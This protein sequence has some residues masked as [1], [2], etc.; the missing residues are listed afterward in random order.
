VSPRGPLS[1]KTAS[2]AAPVAD[3]TRRV[4]TPRPL[5]VHS[6]T[7]L[8]RPQ[9]LALAAQLVDHFALAYGRDVPGLS[10]DAARFLVTRRWTLDDLAA[11]LSRAVAAN[12]GSLITAADL[13]G[14]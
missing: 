8:Y 10:A 11:C 3:P 13:R 1:R 9:L 4:H 6:A 14:L 12:Q 2:D 5:L 7:P